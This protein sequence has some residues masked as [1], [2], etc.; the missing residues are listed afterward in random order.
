MKKINLII[1]LFVFIIGV[2]CKKSFFDVN[3]SP[4]Q[5]LTASYQLVLPAA[6]NS[7]ATNVSNGLEFS[8]YW[9]GFWAVSGGY[10]PNITEV[11]Y[12]FSNS[13]YQGVW[14]EFYYAIKNLDY[15]EKSAEAIR[16]DKD[17]FYAGIAKALK[18]YCYHNLVDL[19]GN[20]PYSQ[21]LQIEKYPTPKYDDAAAIYA[22]LFVQLDSAR[23]LISSFDD[24]KLV[25]PTANSDIMF[26][27]KQSLWLKF[28]NTLELRLLLRYSEVGTKPSFYAKELAIVNNDANGFLGV[29]QSAMANPGFSNDADAHENP[30]YFDY[31]YSAAGNLASNYGYYRANSYAI[32][33]Y[34]NYNDDRIFFF[35]APYKGSSFAGNDYGVQGLPNKVISGIGL[36]EGS[37]IGSA[38]QS[39]PVLTSFESLFIQAEAAQR[40]L[41]T[42]GDYKALFK[43]ALDESFVYCGYGS[44]PTYASDYYGQKDET[45]NIDISTDPLTTIMTQK[46]ASMNVINPLEVYADYR[47][48]K[49]PADVP[50]SINP[51]AG[52]IPVR[53]L[54]PQ[55][56]INTNPN[57]VKAQGNVTLYTKIFW[58]P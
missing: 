11:T 43:S 2:S 34:E 39:S 29:G 38:T 5:P 18:V 3:T 22:D 21:A 19:Y 44:D 13:Y 31:G 53:L 30:F 58:Q 14:A 57:S 26:Q 15:I 32:N 10:A 1:V 25:G 37:I 28:I 24:T 51:S 9:M 48:T 49:I 46:W 55:T 23:T 45:V 52:D 56:E 40:G 20:V 33:F 35:Y 7:I 4:N 12:K 50:G 6:L 17:V 41:L 36:G 54:Y 8:K 16:P 47:R 42:G 27:G